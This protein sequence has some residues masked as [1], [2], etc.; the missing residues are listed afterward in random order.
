LNQTQSL[1]GLIPVAA[2][3]EGSY[4][5]FGDIQKSFCDLIE[6]GSYAICTDKNLEK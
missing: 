3:D 1:S 4:R 2:V 6:E 5:F